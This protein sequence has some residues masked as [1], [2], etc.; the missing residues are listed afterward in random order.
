ML[1]EFPLFKYLLTELC[2]GK[3]RQFDFLLIHCLPFDANDD[4]NW[5][6]AFESDFRMAFGWKNE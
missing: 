4:I 6:Y 1:K 3:R 5:N 2:D